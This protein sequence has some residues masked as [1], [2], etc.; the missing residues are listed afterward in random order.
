ML[1]DAWPGDTQRA[2]RAW[3][4]LARFAMRFVTTVRLDDARGAHGPMLPNNGSITLLQL[5]TR[6]AGVTC[7]HVVD[8]YREQRLESSSRVFKVGALALDPLDR[9]VAADPILDLAVFDLDD[10]DPEQLTVGAYQPAFFQ[11]GAWPLG[12]AEPEDLVGLGGYP[13]F[14]RAR[15]PDPDQSPE[16]SRSFALG[17]T[18][19]IDVGSE[20]IVCEAS[21]DYWLEGHDP[22]RIGATMDLGGLS[23]GPGFVRRGSDY[24]IVGVIFVVARS[25]GFL[26]LRPARFVREDGSL[27]RG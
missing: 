12:T 24:H 2:D 20:N 3:G 18:R 19:V 1:S 11:P 5:P 25:G 16:T 14:C 26:R 21:W 6:R 17:A 4:E 22:R 8:A 13:G 9:L 7:F 27:G 23:G 10:V 15:S